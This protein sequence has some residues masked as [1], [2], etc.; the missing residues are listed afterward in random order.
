MNPLRCLLLLCCASVLLSADAAPI[1]II[2]LGDSITKGVRGGVTV[3]ET[4]AARV[5]A[6]L[7]V[8]D[9]AVE[10]INTGIGGE[11]TDQALARLDKDIVAL[12]P[13]IVVIMYGTNDSYVDVGRT[14]PRLTVQ[15]Y[16]ANLVNLVKQ[17]RAAGIVPILMTE[18]RWGRAAK[19]NGAG[20]H[21]NLRLE[22]YVEACRAVAQEMKVP[23]ADHFRVWTEQETK[24][25][26][27]GTWTTD[28]CHPNPLGHQ[29]LADTLLPI[30]RAAL[31]AAK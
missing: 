4:F 12:K 29:K 14:E 27:V 6:T 17:L 1:R 3:Q 25:V 20:E 9:I 8:Q 23:L 21:P 11:R 24:G 31:P 13:A 26:D 7:R 16:R 18:P 15:E 19:P 22:K 28:Q 30:L 5:E 10:V 2:A